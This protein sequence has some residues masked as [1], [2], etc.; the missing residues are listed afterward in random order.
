MANT[1]KIKRGPESNLTNDS[2]VEGE[3]G[4]TTDSYKLLIGTSDGYQQLNSS[5]GPKNIV[6]GDST[7]SVRTV[8]SKATR[9]YAFAEG[10]GTIASDFG[11]HAENVA[12]TASGSASHAEGWQTEATAEAAHS[13]GIQT[14]ASG[15]YSHV[16]GYMTKATGQSQHVQGKLNVSD[17]NLAHIVGNG[18]T[19]KYSNAHTL[20]WEG[21]AWFA[22]DVYVGSTSGTNKDD[23]SKKLA[24]EEYVDTHRSIIT[25]TKTEDN[26]NWALYAGV[27]TAQMDTVL[28]S[29]GSG[30]EFWLGNVTG[31][32]GHKYLVSGVVR[33]SA[34]NNTSVTSYDIGAGIKIGG[35]D[36]IYFITRTLEP[37]DEITESI[38]IPPT[39]VSMGADVPNTS[40]NIGVYGSAFNS[41][42]QRKTLPGSYIT[43]ELVD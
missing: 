17:T 8:N 21:N 1:I 22:G 7:G 13:E 34:T 39:L 9:E 41:N 38:I 37:G 40:I 31:S 26:E 2:L 42:V 4:Y 5:S 28:Y 11:A 27:C 16:E 15:L 33:Y 43:V 20:D 23:G 12:T 6:D 18:T 24:T 25:V 29:C 36:Q 19:S 14:V 3:I 30:L 35:T 10:T 32:E